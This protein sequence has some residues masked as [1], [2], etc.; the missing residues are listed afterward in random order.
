MSPKFLELFK[1]LNRSIVELCPADLLDEPDRYQP[2]FSGS[3]RFNKNWGWKTKNRP[4]TWLEKQLI[5]DGVDLP[6]YLYRV[7]GVPQGA[8][9]SCSLSTLCLEQV[10]LPQ[11]EICNPYLEELSSSTK[12]IMYADDGLIFSNCL[13][14]IE[15]EKAKLEL[16]GSSI[17]LEKSSWFKKDVRYLKTLKFCGLLYDPMLDSVSAS[18]RSYIDNRGKFHEGS[19]LKFSSKEKLLCFLLSIRDNLFAIASSDTKLNLKKYDGSVSNFIFKGLTEYLNLESKVAPLFK[20]NWCGIF[21]SK[22]Y[23]GSYNNYTKQNQKLLHYKGSWFDCCLWEYVIKRSRDPDTMKKYLSQETLWAL[24]NSIDSTINKSWFSS[25]TF[26]KR[27]K[28]WAL[29]VRSHIDD[30]LLKFETGKF[31]ISGS[32]LQLRKPTE[33]FPFKFS[34][35]SLLLE[36]SYT[37]Y[38]LHLYIEKGPSFNSHV[39]T[40]R[41]NNKETYEIIMSRINYI[42]P[43]IS[44]CS[45]FACEDLVSKGGILDGKVLDLK[46]NYQKVKII[47]KMKINSLENFPKTV[48]SLNKFPWSSTGTRFNLLNEIHPTLNYY[49][50]QPWLILKFPEKPPVYGLLHGLKK[51]VKNELKKLKLLISSVH[52]YLG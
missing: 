17:S 40:V 36:V 6:E 16:S 23:N 19:S 24:H 12:T 43:V 38:I 37:L 46:K 11:S 51:R 8:A 33:P 21:L 15:R 3:F 13:S 10:T 14:D 26:N 22:L 50:K 30:C 52:R 31:P 39:D 28:A 1:K 41:D 32:S 20:S 49:V 45:S 18:T 48:T 27:T 34:T 9:T 25:D 5:E 2:T 35:N 47:R 42:K 7:K 44:N 4:L 29:S